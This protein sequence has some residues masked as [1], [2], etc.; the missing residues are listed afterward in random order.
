MGAVAAAL[1]VAVPAIAVA[2]TTVKKT[3]SV[4][5]TIKQASIASTGTPPQAGSTDTEAG[6]VKS[7]IAS[8]AEV[9][10]ITWGNAGAFTATGTL[11][12]G[13]GS[14]KIK[15][16]GTLT[17]SGSN[18]VTSGKGTVAGGT[19]AYKGAT[20]KFTFTGSRPVNGTVSTVVITGKVK[21]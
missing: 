19:G 1:L 16:S 18:L 13:K 3:H 8:G 9:A 14:V 6:S 20:G 4:T 7:N 15:S 5:A 10:T 12:S 11:F 2:A 21:Y 17:V